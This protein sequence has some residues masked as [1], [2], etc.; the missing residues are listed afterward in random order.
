MIIFQI[1]IVQKESENTLK[2]P[3]Q[4][5]LIGLMGAILSIFP[6]YINTIGK[7][8]WL[9]WLIS[10]D[11]DPSGLLFGVTGGILSLIGLI[12]IF[13]SINS[14][15]KIEKCREIMWEFHEIL[16]SIEDKFEIP[17][18]KTFELYR[19]LLSYKRV[20]TPEIFVSKVIIAARF[21]IVCVLLMW[22]LYVGIVD[23][24]F[25]NFFMWIVLVIGGVILLIFYYILG[26]LN[27][28]ERISDLS[29]PVSL[30]KKATDDKEIDMKHALFHI[31]KFNLK[32]DINEN[33][34]LMV[35]EMDNIFN[36]VEFSVH[37]IIPYV[38]VSGTI[39]ELSSYNFNDS[40]KI[41]KKT[42]HIRTRKLIAFFI[43]L[44]SEEMEPSYEANE[45]SLPKNTVMVLLKCR[46]EQ[47][48][49][50]WDT[51]RIKKGLEYVYYPVMIDNIDI[52]FDEP[53]KIV[54]ED[55]VINAI[56][57]T[58]KS[59]YSE[60]GWAKQVHELIAGED[61]ELYKN[62]VKIRSE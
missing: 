61:N 5:I 17:H 13:V 34:T 42:P 2:L 27:D 4:E 32:W 9:T 28:F 12:A 16:D 53:L 15:H 18:N 52:N 51:K 6:I 1:I 30:V 38:L 21:S 36:G 59:F 26:R 14:Q 24:A 58:H 20:Y 57:E 19:K 43:N 50:I 49:D 55:W 33:K 11:T 40:I 56:E 7:G 23:A 39:K 44:V 37:S 29:K 41:I 25:V 31:S 22:C 62:I 3:K 47:V 46:F 54:Y 45:M 60:K 10:K 8:Y 35:Y 48:N